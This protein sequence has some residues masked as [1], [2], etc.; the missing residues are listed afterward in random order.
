MKEVVE[1]HAGYWVYLVEASE[2]T[3]TS[4]VSC[5]IIAHAHLSRVATTKLLVTAFIS[6]VAMSAK[7]IM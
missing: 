1:G 7:N 6:L 3:Q 5:A 2:L 4:D